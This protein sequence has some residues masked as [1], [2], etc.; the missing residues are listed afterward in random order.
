MDAGAW[1]GTLKPS[2]VSPSRPLPTKTQRNIHHRISV[3]AN[4]AAAQIR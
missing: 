3:Q 2:S 1:I 4:R